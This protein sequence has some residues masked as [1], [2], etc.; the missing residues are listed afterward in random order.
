MFKDASHEN[1]KVSTL[2]QPNCPLTYVSTY[3]SSLDR[4]NLVL[5]CMATS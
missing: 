5:K 1:M 4:W 2:K 3:L